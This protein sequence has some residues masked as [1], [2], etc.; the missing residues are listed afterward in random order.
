MNKN[1]LLIILL[2]FIF[3]EYGASQNLIKPATFL[4]RRNSCAL[5]KGVEEREGAKVPEKI[6]ASNYNVDKTD[7][8][9]WIITVDT[10]SSDAPLI[11]SSGFLKI[12]SLSQAKILNQMQFFVNVLFPYSYRFWRYF[13]FLD[14]YFIFID[15]FKIFSYV[16][17]NSSRMH[18][19]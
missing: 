13:L 9:C 10:M 7:F 15:F 4:H 1:H 18:N 6:P 14:K 12:Q 5:H 17:L 3:D 11:H 2:F 8:N 19:L 16:A